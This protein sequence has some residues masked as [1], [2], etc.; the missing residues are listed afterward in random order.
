MGLW[1][2]HQALTLTDGFRAH[3]RGTQN[4][5]GAGVIPRRRITQS[6]SGLG[7]QPLRTSGGM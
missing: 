6:V 3:P 1:A 7:D 2:D 5:D 4:D